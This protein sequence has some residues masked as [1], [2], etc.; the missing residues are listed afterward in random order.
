M[1]HLARHD[2]GAGDGRFDHQP[3]AAVDRPVELATLLEHDGIGGKRGDPLADR[4]QGGHASG[5][6]F[7][8]ELRDRLIGEL[9]DLGPS[10]HAGPGRVD[11]VHDVFRCRLAAQERERAHLRAASPRPPKLPKP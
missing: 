3:E 4:Q 6:V 10:R 11:A 5:G 2:L 8:V 9:R 1:Q 7:P